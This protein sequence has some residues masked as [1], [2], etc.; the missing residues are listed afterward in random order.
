MIEFKMIARY[1]EEIDSIEILDNF[2][3]WC[4]SI[5]INNGKFQSFEFPLDDDTNWN[6]KVGKL[7]DIKTIESFAIECAWV[8]GIDEDLLY[9]DFQVELINCDGFNINTQPVD[10]DI[11]N[12]WMKR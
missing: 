5:H 8:S 3:N 10:D 2:M 1:D 6:N 4:G 9:E 11:F 12:A 7:V